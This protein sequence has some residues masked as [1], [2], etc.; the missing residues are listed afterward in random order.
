[1]FWCRKSQVVVPFL[2]VQSLE[3]TTSRSFSSSEE[4]ESH[5]PCQTCLADLSKSADMPTKELCKVLHDFT[6]YFITIIVIL[7]L[8]LSISHFIFKGDSK[9]L[10]ISVLQ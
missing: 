6:H 9:N 8:Q 5:I 1:M 10:E 7:F 4:D 2:A 3:G